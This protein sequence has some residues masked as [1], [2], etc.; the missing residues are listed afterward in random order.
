[1]SARMRTVHRTLGAAAALLA[2]FAAITG[3]PTAPARVSAAALADSGRDDAFVART[4]DAL[5]L[6]AWIREGAR[7][8][9]VLDLRDRAAYEVE[10]VP[11]AEVA[12]FARLDTLARRGDAPVVVYSDDDVR[13]AQAWANLAA[14]GHRRAYVLAGG[15]DAWT[16]EVMEPVLRGDSADY[17]AALSRY[18]GGAPR[19]PRPQDDEISP[20]RTKVARRA[21]PSS[22]TQPSPS[23]ERSPSA[24]QAATATNEFGEPRRRGC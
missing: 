3:T 18:F 13:D 8:V 11:S 22:S 6:A 1:M 2:A 17:V 20:A 14:R 21:E 19:A 7:D 12:D 15:M 4:V 10:H 16:R 9:R 23:A 24:E 5:Q